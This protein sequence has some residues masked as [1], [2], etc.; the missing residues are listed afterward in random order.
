MEGE[1]LLLRGVIEL[2]PNLVNASMVVVGTR[3]GSQPELT[4]EILDVEDDGSGLRLLPADGSAERC[5]LI[6]EQTEV[7]MI[8]EDEGRGTAEIVDPDDSLVGL[9]ADIFGHEDNGG[10]FAAGTVI[11]FE[12]PEATPL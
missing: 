4:G 3:A 6:G 2:D 7:F 5:V 9:Q 8:T 10:C 11:A 1:R 12:A